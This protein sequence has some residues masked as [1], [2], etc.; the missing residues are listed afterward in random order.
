MYLSNKNQENDEIIRNIKDID[1]SIIFESSVPME[2]NDAHLEAR[3][4][5]PI[6]S[7]PIEWLMYFNQKNDEVLNQEFVDQRP[8]EAVVIDNDNQQI[9]LLKSDN[10]ISEAFEYANIQDSWK[11]DSNAIKSIWQNIMVDSVRISHQDKEVQWTNEETNHSSMVDASVQYDMPSREKEQ[12]F[13]RIW[14]LDNSVSDTL[15]LSEISVE[16][17]QILIKTGVRGKI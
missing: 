10:N 14:H 7:K 3:I 9:S 6:K 5:L 17:Q 13:I 2:I 16:S 12:E 1:Q 15:N 4:Q 11:S 8:W